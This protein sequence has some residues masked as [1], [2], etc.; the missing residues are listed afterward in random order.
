MT[1]N[2]HPS[3][4]FLHRQSSARS[5]TDDNECKPHRE[6][7][8]SYIPE[9]SREQNP[10]G[11]YLLIPF[12]IAT[13]SWSNGLGV[14]GYEIASGF[15]RSGCGACG[16]WC[17]SRGGCPAGQ[18]TAV[19]G[20]RSLQKLFVSRSLP[21]RRLL[22]APGQLLRAG[23]GTRCRAVRSESAAVAS[24]GLGELIL[25]KSTPPYPFTEWPYGGST[26]IGV[27]RPNSVD[28]PFMTAISNTKAGQW[29]NDAHIQIYGWVNVGGNV[30]SNTVKPGGNW[31]AAYACHTRRTRSSSIRRSSISSACRTR[32]SRITSTGAS[33]SRRS[34]VR[35]SA[36]PPHTVWRAISCWDTTTRRAT[37]SRWCMAKSTSRTSWT[38]W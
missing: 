32:Y 27:T 24:Q 3:A 25:G 8:K 2:L 16:W 14:F 10:Y 21:W 33:A 38:A 34:T 15:E 6:N 11:F 12:E 23:M 4:E 9:T 28:S 13:V 26:S 29:L 17:G 19:H 37:T 20:V 35:T 18:G 31:P 7:Q 22:H 1:S 5:R 30:S 36:T